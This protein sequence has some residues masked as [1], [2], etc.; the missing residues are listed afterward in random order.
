MTLG[1]IDINS[2][3]IK[4]LES[5]INKLNIRYKKCVKP[6][7]FIGTSKLILPGVGAFPDFMKRLEERNLIEV[8]IQKSNENVPFLGIC[9][10]YQVLFAESKEHKLTKGL[11]LISGSFLHFNE[12]NKD[13]KVPHVGWNNCK[14]LKKSP[15]FADIKDN[16]DF[17]FDHSFYLNSKSRDC[18]VTSTEYHTDFIS[19][20]NHKNIYGVQFHP[21]KSQDNGIK[22]LKNFYENC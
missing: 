12:Y 13:I 10:G 20:I 14:F 7:D 8:I 1:L 21:E 3:N 6:E 9:A 18:F 19:S 5:A 2:G 16:T 22:C 17:Y 15:L 4:S 11:N